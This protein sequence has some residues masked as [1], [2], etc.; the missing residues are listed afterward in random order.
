MPKKCLE[1]L[2]ILKNLLKNVKTETYGTDLENYLNNDKFTLVTK[3]T[4]KQNK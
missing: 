1:S 3:L 4:N 2:T